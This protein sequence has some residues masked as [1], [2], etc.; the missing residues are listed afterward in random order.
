MCVRHRVSQ[1]LY[2]SQLIE[3]HACVDP[4]YGELQVGIYVAAIQDAMD[5]KQQPQAPVSHGALTSG[6]KGENNNQGSRR[7]GPGPRGKPK[8]RCGGAKRGRFQGSA[9]E[10]G[11][12]DGELAVEVN[13]SEHCGTFEA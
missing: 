4:G 1:T 6:S 10:N 7:G 3:P 2:V 5:R 11:P 8:G 12:T 9:A 13:C